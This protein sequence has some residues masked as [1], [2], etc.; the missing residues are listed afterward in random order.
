MVVDGRSGPVL[1]LASRPTVSEGKRRPVL[2]VRGHV[3]GM[4]LQDDRPFGGVGASGMGKYHGIG[5]LAEGTQTGAGC[6][7]SR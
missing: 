6:S 2:G 5:T 1:A 3:G 4:E 7:R